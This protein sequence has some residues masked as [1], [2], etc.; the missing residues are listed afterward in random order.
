MHGT[1]LIA[2]WSKV[3]A[4][5]APSSGEAEL[6]AAS[7]GISEILGVRHL[8]D[9][10]SIDIKMKLYVDA[11][12]AKGA[13]LRKGAGRIKHL[14]VRQLWCQAMVEKYGI[15]VQ[16]IPRKINLADVLTHAVPRRCLNLFHEAVNIYLT[17]E[18]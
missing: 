11:S 7:K 18:P 4:T 8:L 3:Q 5:P 1:H 9:E 17:A 16:T 2:H 14:E 15:E 13:I 6:N 12:A 10:M